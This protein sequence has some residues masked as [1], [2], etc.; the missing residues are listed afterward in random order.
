MVVRLCWLSLQQGTC[1]DSR[2]EGWVL[3]PLGGG[4]RDQDLVANFSGVGSYCT[5]VSKYWKNSQTVYSMM[6]NC[7]K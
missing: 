3:G 2:R 5:V 7:S 6:G 4:I 1:V